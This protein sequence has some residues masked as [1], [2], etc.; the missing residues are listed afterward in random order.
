MAA[1]SFLDNLLANPSP[2]NSMLAS[3]PILDPLAAQA[4][5]VGDFPFKAPPVS[6]LARIRQAALDAYKPT[7][8][9]TNTGG[10]GG[11]GGTGGAGVA[12]GGGGDNTGQRELTKAEVM[13]GMRGTSGNNIEENA[14]NAVSNLKELE[15]LKTVLPVYVYLPLKL[16]FESQRDAYTAETGMSFKD[17]GKGNIVKYSDDDTVKAHNLTLFGGY[18]DAQGN[19]VPGGSVKDQLKAELSTPEAARL[20]NVKPASETGT[21]AQYQEGTV[22][23]DGSGNVIVSGDGSPVLTSKGSSLV[24]SGK[25]IT[26]PMVS[27]TGGSSGGMLTTPNNGVTVDA[28]IQ[29]TIAPVT[30]VAPIYNSGLDSSSSGGGYTGSGGYGG[31]GSLESTY[32]GGL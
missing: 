30:P 6:N 28:P 18:F 32:G 4:R 7:T 19:W 10:A 15:K 12:S 25:S 8:T 1:S 27:N 2:R 16:Q 11:A 23:L 26:M 13:E 22:V 21:G 14:R 17:D 29:K 24:S 5:K 31:G 20:A 9:E 3:A